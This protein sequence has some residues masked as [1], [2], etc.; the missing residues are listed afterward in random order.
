MFLVVCI[1]TSIMRYSTNVRVIHG[2]VLSYA[3]A[4]IPHWASL[5]FVLGADGLSQ[6]RTWDTSLWLQF[7]IPM[8]TLGIKVAYLAG[9]FGPDGGYQET[10]RKR[11][12]RQGKSSSSKRKGE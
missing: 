1:S 7:I 6:W 3:L 5:F 2:L 9:A 8:F 4:D 10:P 11:S 12:R